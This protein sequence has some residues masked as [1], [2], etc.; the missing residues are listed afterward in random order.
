M[1]VGS[2]A[3]SPLIAS[4]PADPSVFSDLTS[5]SWALL[6]ICQLCGFSRTL[7]YLVELGSSLPCSQEPS[8]GPWV[9]TIQSIVHNYIYLRIHLCLCLSSGLFPSSFL[10]NILYVFLFSPFALHTHL[11]LFYWLFQLHLT[12]STRYMYR[13][14][15]KVKLSRNRPWRPTGLWNVKDPTLSRHSDHRWR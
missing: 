2:T 3:Y 14:K 4:F 5:W 12:N 11:I 10:T 1:D 8:T 15:V 7:K 13:Y 6:T 9:T